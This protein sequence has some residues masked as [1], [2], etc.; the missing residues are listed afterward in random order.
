MIKI[1]APSDAT[2]VFGDLKIRVKQAG[3][4]RTMG[5]FIRRKFELPE[6]KAELQKYGFVAD[7][8]SKIIGNSLEQ[9][10]SRMT[11]HGVVNSRYDHSL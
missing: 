8:Y 9:F 6:V 10:A 11:L 4:R 1:A 7:N 2:F 5:Y 3:Q